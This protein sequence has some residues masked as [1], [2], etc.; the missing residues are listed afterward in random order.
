ML[1]FTNGYGCAIDQEKGEVIL[2]FVQQI[3]EF[4]DENERIRTEEIVSLV[5]GRRTVENLI[6]SLQEI[7]EETEE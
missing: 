4:E 7:L 6:K 5:M 2:K 1:Q 3:P